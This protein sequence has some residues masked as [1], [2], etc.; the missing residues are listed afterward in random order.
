MAT[1]PGC[2]QLCDVIPNLCLTLMPDP[3]H[4]NVIDESKDYCR[5]EKAAGIL[6]NCLE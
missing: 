1:Q 6:H 4:L 5:T 2:M 3:K